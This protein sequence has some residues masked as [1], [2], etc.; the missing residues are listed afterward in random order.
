MIAVA[1]A[2]GSVGQ[3]VT[4]EVIRSGELVRVLTRDAAR[5]ARFGDDVEVHVVDY[6]DPST[7]ERAFAGADRAFIA[8]GVNPRQ[9]GDEMKLI[10][11]AA[12]RGVDY[13]VK[14]SVQ[15]AGGDYPV[16]VQRWN[17]EIENAL[18]SSGLTAT[19]VRPATFFKAIGLAPRPLIDAG[20]WGGDAGTGRA[21][22][23]GHD[24]VGVFAARLLLDRSIE[25]ASGSVDVEVVTGPDSLTIDNVQTLL[26]AHLGR[27]V[28]YVRRSEVE[29]RAILEDLGL[30]PLRI[31]VLLGLDAMLRDSIMAD[32]TDSFERLVGRR[33]VS[34]AE[35]LTTQDA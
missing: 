17:T 8:T 11:A 6:D 21:A 14:L 13:A 5:A 32:V 20:L 16:I 28:T 1:G 2:T 3:A 35:W 7:L 9:V 29:Q 23:V 12:D 24:D 25:R 31:E 34:F 18:R 19:I 22:F 10:T 30:P 4:R 26:T 33:P 15:G 27:A